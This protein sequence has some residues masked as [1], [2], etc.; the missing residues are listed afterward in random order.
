MD[1]IGPA[2]RADIPALK[3]IWKLS[4]G[5]QD[6][7]IDFY[8]TNRYQD[9]ETLLLRSGPDVLAMLAML[10]VITVTPAN[11]S[12]ASVMIYAMA[13]HPLHRHNGLAARIMEFGAQSLS[14]VGKVFSVLV[15]QEKSLFDFYRK[16][17]Y[18]EAF[19]LR[20][21]LLTRQQIS[22]L[23]AGTPTGLTVKAGNP[24]EYNQ[25]RNERLS[26]KFYIAYGQ[27]DI[28]YQ[29]KLCQ[30]SGGDIY[31]VTSASSR[32]CAVIERVSAARV[33]IKEMLAPEELIPPFLQELSGQVP[34]ASYLIR[35]PAYSGESLGGTIRPFGMIKQHTQQREDRVP[36]EQG[37][38]GLAFD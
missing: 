3:E 20:E 4:F 19:Y 16:F 10:P 7:Y 26:G 21:S 14:A 36:Q 28:R 30:W 6:A 29:Q 34:A 22:Q 1:T 33:V 31:L 13:T 5:D 25:I 35:T 24:E 17:G 23:A 38:L 32:G 27:T 15:P 18:E 8:Y 9:E 37:Y 12:L 2:A 11:G